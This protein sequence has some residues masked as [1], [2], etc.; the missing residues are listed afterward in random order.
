[1]V[2]GLEHSY[3]PKPVA[4]AIPQRDDRVQSRHPTP[5]AV[6]PM[7]EI[8]NARSHRPYMEALLR[9][10]I[11]TA[12]TD[13]TSTLLCEETVSN[14]SGYLA[15]HDNNHHIDRSLSEPSS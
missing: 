2:P 6:A 11:N 13:S 5:R 7:S 8:P 10:A 12:H 1:M 4:Y 9:E 3:P 15:V 14:R